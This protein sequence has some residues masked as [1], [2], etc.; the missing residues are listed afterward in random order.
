MFYER[1]YKKLFHMVL[2]R[3][4]ADFSLKILE[5]WQTCPTGIISVEDT[6]YGLLNATNARN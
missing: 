5:A 2:S 4:E 1:T 3:G 6:K